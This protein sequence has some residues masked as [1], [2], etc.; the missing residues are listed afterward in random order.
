MKKEAYKE[1]K[2]YK[3][4]EKWFHEIQMAAKMH[5]YTFVIVAIIHL[6]IPFVYMLLFNSDLLK[7]VWQ[8]FIGFHVQLWGKAIQVLFKKGFLIFV[9]ATPVWLLYP[10]LLGRFKLKAKQI[11]QDQ[12][13]RGSKLI[14]D[15]ELRKM[16]L[17]DIKH[18]K[19]F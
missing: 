4:F 5:L 8:I 7:T 6:S 13:L 19:R 2:A 16:V 11:M 10:A 9:L 1:P 18:E 14:S 12:H 17:N 15:D 3:G